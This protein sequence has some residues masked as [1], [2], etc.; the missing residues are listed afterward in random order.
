MLSKI[1]QDAINEQI[2]K[3][4]YSAY[5]YLAMTAHFEGENLPG[6]AHWMRVQ[7]REETGHG[8]KFFSYIYE[9]GGNVVL[10]A[11]AQPPTTFKTP[12]SIFEQVLKHEQQITKSINKLYELALK[13]KDYPTQIMLEWFIKEQV[14]EEQ[15]DMRIIEQLKMAGEAPIALLMLDRQLAARAQ[16]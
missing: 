14:E 12:L 8:M 15:T 16:G 5:L 3:E 9:R 2:N 11:I 7:A 4:F 10:E 13:E 1:M 6:F